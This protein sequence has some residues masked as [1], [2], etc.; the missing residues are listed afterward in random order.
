MADSW[1]EEGKACSTESPQWKLV[2]REIIS[3]AAVCSNNIHQLFKEIQVSIKISC[4]LLDIVQDF[5]PQVGG[6]L[7][8]PSFRGWCGFNGWVYVIC[9][10]IEAICYL[11]QCIR[12]EIGGVQT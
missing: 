9:G 2:R 6:K 1:T 10:V 7:D 3:M 4:C 12:V 11:S 8:F 5:L